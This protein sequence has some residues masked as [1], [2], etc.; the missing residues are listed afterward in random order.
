MNPSIVQLDDFK[1]DDIPTMPIWRFTVEQY[2]EMIRA[3]ILPSGAPVELLEGWLVRKMIK[4][5]PHRVATRKARLTLERVL[6]ERWSVD[7]QEPIT[8][9]DS[10]PEPDVSVIKGDTTRLIDRHPRPDEIELVVEV[11]DTSLGQD[12]GPKKRIYAAARIP[13][14][15]IINLMDR[16]VEVYRSPTG[17]LQRSDYELQDIFGTGDTIPLALEGQEVARIA[18]VDLLPE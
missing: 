13:T 10:E 15:W 16:C 5:P 6:R 17:P 14:Y 8:T 2:H 9:L 18:V 1:C 11:A 3:G 12:R 4:N 7:T